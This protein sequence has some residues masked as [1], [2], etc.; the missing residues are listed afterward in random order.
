MLLY[1]LLKSLAKVTSPRLG[2]E[3]DPKM[4]KLS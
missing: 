2:K 3:P 4:S 1:I